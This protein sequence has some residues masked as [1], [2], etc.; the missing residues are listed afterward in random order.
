MPTGESMSDLEDMDGSMSEA[1]EEAADG[2]DSEEA[3]ELV[4]MAEA[5]LLAAIKA[6]QKKRKLPDTNGSAKGVHDRSI[7]QCTSMQLTSKE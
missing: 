7:A 1:E 2:D 5:D 4:D 3:P 6:N